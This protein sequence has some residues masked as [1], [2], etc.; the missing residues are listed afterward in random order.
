MKSLFDRLNLRPQER[1]L[2][3]IVGLIVFVLL[4]MWFVWP[5]FGEWGLLAAKMQ[6]SR[7]TLAKYQAEIARRPEYEKRR[8]DLESIGSQML[9]DDLEL[10]RI[11]TTH[12]ATAGVQ[13]TRTDPR[14]RVSGT[15]TN[16]FFQEQ[17]L[18]I[19]FSTG[20]KELVDF[21][22]GIASGNSMIRIRQMNVKPDPSQTRL[23]GNII[24]IGNYQGRPASTNAPA[25]GPASRRRT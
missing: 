18:S 6:K 14:A 16:Q 20:G 3:V 13:I 15:R 24:F 19:D 5:Y 23:T 1:R 7:D 21:L 8:A 25:G 2:V 22:V 4:N 10:Q 11:V 12:A 9:A 17:T